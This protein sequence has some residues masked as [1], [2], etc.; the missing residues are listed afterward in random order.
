MNIKDLLHHEKA[1][2]TAMLLKTEQASATAIQILQGEQLK[3]HI[4]KVSALLICILGTA[5]FENEKGVKETLQAGDYISID[6]MIKHWVN[7]IR[8]SQL[9]LF[10]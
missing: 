8:D 2:S 6:P 10:K 9:I 1:I 5:V 3:E 7:A 4:T